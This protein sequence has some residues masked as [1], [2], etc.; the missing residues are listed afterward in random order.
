MFLFSFILIV[1]F[2]NGSNQVVHFAYK[3]QISQ[4]FKKYICICFLKR[5][6]ETAFGLPSELWLKSRAFFK[7]YVL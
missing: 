3:F 1:A 2:C 6:F 5:N 4:E 7:V